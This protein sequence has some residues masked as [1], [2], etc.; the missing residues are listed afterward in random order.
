M[1]AVAC[2]IALGSNLGDSKATL[3][4]ALSSLAQAPG[5]QLIK[6]SPWYWTLPVGPPQPN[7]LNGCALLHVTLTPHELLHTL[8]TIEAS[9]QRT[10]QGLNQPRT[11]DLDVLLF[12]SM[13]LDLPDLQIPHPRMYDRA[14]VLVPLADIAPDWIE[15]KSGK[16]IAQLLQAVDQVGIL[17]IES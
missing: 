13:I 6:Q 4:A 3:E 10:R 12:G 7:Y 2:A 14:F 9:F 17:G 16:M 11:L 5:I 8:L 1:S 15:P